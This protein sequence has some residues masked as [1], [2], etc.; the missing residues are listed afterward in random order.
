MQPGHAGMVGRAGWGAGDRL[1]RLSG[2]VLS[3]CSVCRSFVCC[4][5]ACST[6]AITIVAAFEQMPVSL[7][8]DEI[9]V[10]GLARSDISL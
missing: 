2:R 8:G 5:L 4:A 6:R 1:G 9:Y 3:H 7:L 10:Y